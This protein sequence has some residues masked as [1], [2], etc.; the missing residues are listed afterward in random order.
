MPDHQRIFQLIE[1][2]RR[3][4]D[5]LAAELNS[6]QPQD[7]PVERALSPG[8]APRGARRFFDPARVV[9]PTQTDEPDS[10]V[11]GAPTREFPDCCAVGNETQYYCT[12]TLI[13]PTI[14]VTARHC[15]NLKRAF[16]RGHDI[17]DP[18]GG[19]TIEI[20]KE[21]A[22]PAADLRVL[23]L[24]TPSTVAPRHVAQGAEVEAQRALLVGFGTVDFN[25]TVGY[26]IKR[27]VEV[28]IISM[29]CSGPGE[30][31]RYGCHPGTEMI[32]GHRGLDRDS[33]RGDSGGPLYI[34]GADGTHHLLGVTSRG[35]GGP[36]VCGDG[37]IYVRVDQFLDWIRSQT[38]VS[39]PGSLS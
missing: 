20:D 22:H 35:V 11:G 16:L 21:F 18:A 19:E 2:A 12:G 27:K 26:G 37:G 1:G 8:G 38:G 6:L 39:I 32:A 13:A 30:D 25:G 31:T 15:P 28:P 3:Q 33:C 4:L 34:L 9:P 24:R 10:I 17:S 14:I 5:E 23:V 29:S 36:R 7:A